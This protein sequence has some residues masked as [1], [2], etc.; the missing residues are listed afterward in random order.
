MAKNNLTWNDY[1]HGR[2]SP[3][4]GSFTSILSRG[5]RRG[6]LSPQEETDE[7]LG[8]QSNRES[9]TQENDLRRRRSSIALRINALA[10]VGGVNSVESFARSWQRAINFHEIT[11]SRSSF[12]V[13]E[14][15]QGIIGQ[16]P[17]EEHGQTIHRSLLRQQLEQE[18]TPSDVAVQEDVEETEAISRLTSRNRVGGSPSRGDDDIFSQASYLG[19]PMGSTYNGTYGS[20]TAAL[21]DSSKQHATRLFNEQ[22]ATGLQEPDKECE[23]L[24]VKRVE[25]ED[26]KIVLAVVGQSTIYQTVLNSTNVLIGVG[27]LSLPLGINYAGWLIGLLFLSFAAIITAYTARLLGKCLDVDSGLI[28]FADV[29]NVAFGSRAKI[30]IGILFSLELIAAC[31]AL[32][33]LFAD[34]LDALIPGWGLLEWKILCGVIMLPLCFV[35]L[36]LLGYSSSLGIICCFGIVILVFV[37]GLLK[38]HTPGSL[39][40]PATTYLF[41]QSWYTLPLSF[42]L[43]MSPW[44]GH[45][46][47]PNIYRDMRH[48]KKYG[49]SLRWT[50]GFTYFL[51]LS[52][53]IAGFLMF[54]NGIL[55][56]V[57]SNIF[58]T[59]GYPN[60]I[61]VLIV[62]CIA[63][64]P[65]TKIPLNARPIFTTVEG[66]LGLQPGHIPDSPGLVGLSGFTRGCLKISIRALTTI[67]ILVIAILC[68]SFDRVMAL[69]GS[70]FCFTICVIL[71]LSFYLKLFGKDIS[72]KERIFD[73]VLIIICS[74]LAVIG[75]VWAFLPKYMT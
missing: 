19:S 75:T 56:E 53:A 74:I 59:D 44:G 27:L 21:N 12:L 4:Q 67:V 63:I 28:T 1:E 71:P 57:T 35:P 41:P 23:P 62:I 18:G 39:R 72:M 31:V 10:Q 54:G 32:F 29:A 68:P 7:L 3:R 11:P 40:E 20:L 49:K 2:S 42:G 34:S 16:R 9:G 25:Q 69:M 8:R 13:T 36:R 52:M 64:I 66:F 50:F 73:W 46:V 6:E 22:Q 37:D 17:D 55:D 15:D 38:P 65:I 14:D 60:A 5:R 47:F 33:V 24:L 43:L 58:V 70:T 30:I 26:G 48:P 61:S 45:S 51:D